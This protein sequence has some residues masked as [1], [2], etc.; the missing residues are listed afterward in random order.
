MF[1]IKYKKIF[2]GISIALVILAIG[3]LAYFGL[4]V[5]IDFKGGALTEVAYTA[6]RPAQ[7]DLNLAPLN[8]G[9]V[10][11]QP[12]G[13]TGYIIKSRDI[14]DAEHAALLKVLSKDGAFPLEEKGFNSIGPSVGHELT[15]KAIVA[16]ILVS[17][18]IILFI[19][20]AFR[21]VSKPVSSWRYGIIAIITLLHDVAI[22]VGIFAILSH[23]YGAEMDTLF[24]VA[25]LTVLGLSISDTIVVF[26]RIREN[27]KNQANVAKTQFAE[28]VGM[29]LKQSYVRSICTSLTVILVLLSL[30]FYGPVSTKYFALMMTAGMFF[31]T[32]SSIF[33][34]SPLLVIIEEAQA[35]K[36][37]SKKSK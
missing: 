6:A 17:L 7:A 3:A 37:A 21:K 29:S 8:I 27:L 31:G 36:A 24:V 2:V 33:L 1:I 19:A 11:V 18:A 15:R 20:Y 26:D 10:L 30:F 25:V 14:S 22:P 12:T 9:E 5:G 28:I 35:K 13:D 34:A 23:Y 16:G 4:N 32:Y